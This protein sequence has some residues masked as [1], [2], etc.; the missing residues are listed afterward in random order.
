M[1]PSTVDKN[2]DDLKALFDKRRGE[3]LLQYGQG[4]WII[5]TA[6]GVAG[7]FAEYHEAVMDAARRLAGKPFLVQQLLP[8]DQIESIQHVH[9]E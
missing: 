3:W 7:V 5:V 6:D 9:W 8:Q 1:A 4:P 2:L